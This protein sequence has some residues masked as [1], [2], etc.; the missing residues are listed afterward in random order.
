MA[1]LRWWGAVDAPRAVDVLGRA[2]DA[3]A[4]WWRPRPWDGDPPWVA[5]HP[6][7]V[8]DLLALDEA[9]LDAVDRAPWRL[10][11]LV[12]AVPEPVVALLVAQ[13][14]E[15]VAPD[16]R[17]V[18]R[19]GVKA[20][21]GAQIDA[22]IGALGASPRAGPVVEWGSGKG[23][24]GR[25]LGA[26]WGAPARLL[27]RD[28]ALCGPP[29]DGAHHVRVDLLRDPVAPLLSPECTVVGLHACGTLTDRLVETACACGV[30]EAA[31]VPCC[32]HRRDAGDPV[33]AVSR[34]ARAAAF[35]FDLVAQRL[36]VL[37]RA[38][39][40]PRRL[41]WR[42]R[43]QHARLV[44]RRL[45]S[46]GGFSPSVRRLRRPALDLPLADLIAAWAEAA[47]EPMPPG[48]AIA[49]AAAWAD[50]AQARIRRLGALRLAAR[51]PLEAWSVLDR[52]AAFAED[53][54]YAVRCEVALPA[55]AS[56]RNLLIHA[57]RRTGVRGVSSEAPD[58]VGTGG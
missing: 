16:V 23:H 56:P 46:L 17:G 41:A 54:R 35:R 39:A 29:S 32:P 30:R 36:A 34:A 5:T 6:T 18:A 10:L 19:E 50:G 27:E 49:E 11:D 25:A 15:P 33:Q 37:D 28:P 21:K 3:S 14:A 51:R 1:S 8:E 47:G 13:Q 48:D 20:R 58:H 40:S 26:V 38:A 57:V 42:V 53:G 7:L 45:A 52:A 55:A 31:V 43:A 44:W 4:Q 24:L 9:T 2:L 22:L 12:R